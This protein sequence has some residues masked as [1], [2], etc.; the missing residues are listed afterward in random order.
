[1]IIVHRVSKNFHHRW[2]AEAF[3]Q[4]EKAHGNDQLIL[5]L[6]RFG[7]HNSR[8]GW[9]VGR[10]VSEADAVKIEQLEQATRTRQ[11]SIVR[12]DESAFETG[13]AIAL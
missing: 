10:Q 13:T 2:E 6:S 5:C 4:Q 9:I 7:G 1:M 8:P 11:S 3:A 12:L